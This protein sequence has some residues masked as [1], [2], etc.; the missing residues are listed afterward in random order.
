MHILL[1]VE[2]ISLLYLNHSTVFLTFQSSTVMKIIDLNCLNSTFNI[3]IIF[4]NNFK[5]YSLHLIA[6]QKHKI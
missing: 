5:T 1:T 3:I 2:Y 4:Y 6:I